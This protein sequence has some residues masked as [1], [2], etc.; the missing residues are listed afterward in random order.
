AG[1]QAASAAK[2]VERRTGSRGRAEA[3]RRRSEARSCALAPCPWSAECGGAGAGAV[4]VEPAAPA[5]RGATVAEAGPDAGFTL[6]RFDSVNHL[7]L[8]ISIS[9][10]GE[11]S[12]ALVTSDRDSVNVERGGQQGKLGG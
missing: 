8:G 2:S 1:R 10:F 9:R 6:A 4:D 7:G 3:A 11:S 5:G 12:A